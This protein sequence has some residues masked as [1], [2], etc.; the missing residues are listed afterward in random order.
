MN[1]ADD[2]YRVATWAAH[3]VTAWNTGGEGIHSPYLFE[4]VRMV[5]YDTHAYYAWNDIE[6]RRAAMLR[7]PKLIDYVDYGSAGG[8]GQHRTRK[9][10][11]IAKGDLEPRQYGELLFRLVNWLGHQLRCEQGRSLNIIELGT[12]LGITAAYMAMADSRN[13]VLTFEGCP[14]VA[15]MARWNWTKLGINNIVCVEGDIDVTLAQHLPEVVDIAF[16]DANHTQEAS[17]R[18]FDTIAKHTHR[19]SV[20]VVDDIYHSRSMHTA[21]QTICAREEVTSTIDLWKMGLVFFDPDYLHKN[22]KLRI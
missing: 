14:A 15:E 20:V 22:Y 13:D 19:K 7:A 16:V 6:K 2:L 9:V 11:D 18:Y 21:W 17:V 8:A 4:W 5:M 12:S 10:S 3:R 1:F